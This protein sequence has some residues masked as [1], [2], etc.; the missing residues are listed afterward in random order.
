MAKK[1]AKKEKEMASEV[2]R[3][4]LADLT[5][6]SYN[7]RKISVEAYQGLGK[8]IDKFGLL[9]PI[10]WNKR[11]GNIVGG[12]QRFRFLMEKGETETDVVVVD[13]DDN[14][15][16]ALNI[17]LNNQAIRGDFTSDVVA[18]LEKAEVQ[19]GSVFNDVGLSELFQDM[20]KKFEKELKAKNKSQEPEKPTPP[21]QPPAPEPPPPDL[22]PE[23]EAIITCPECRSRF[24]MRNNEVVFDSRTAAA[25]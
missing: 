15:E 5:P 10:V 17:T 18:L 4:P 8:S 20:N 16:V 7:P 9:I 12:H 3:M 25:E 1:K 24:K 6:A 13:L 23:P 21:A 11:S 14:E 19:L 2:V 22:P